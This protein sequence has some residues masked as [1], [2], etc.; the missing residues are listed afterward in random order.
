MAVVPA[1]G[2]LTMTCAPLRIMLFLLGTSTRRCTED[3]LG[4]T[5]RSRRLRLRVWHMSQPLCLPPSNAITSPLGWVYAYA[6]IVVQHPV[7]DDA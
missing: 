2:M 7:V 3:E 4:G 6:W 1:L 5:N